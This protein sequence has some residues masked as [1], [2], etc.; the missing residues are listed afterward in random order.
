MLLNGPTFVVEILG[1]V[2]S[3]IMSALPRLMDFL[4]TL[5]V[6]STGASWADAVSALAAFVGLSIA[7]ISLGY[8]YMAWTSSQQNL[9]V[10]RRSFKLAEKEFKEAIARVSQ[11]AKLRCE[12]SLVSPGPADGRERWVR[13]SR[14]RLVWRVEVLNEGDIAAE[15]VVLTSGHVQISSICTGRTSRARELIKESWEEPVGFPLSEPLRTS[16]SARDGQV[17]LLA[18]TL[19]RV[20]VSFPRKPGSLRS[21]QARSISARSRNPQ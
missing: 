18:S 11:R 15:H 3:A 7:V 20:A 2:A 10:A 21:L 1:L 8:A 9:K 4:A 12:F 14:V 19:P 6:T 17:M 16:A 13:N 5:E